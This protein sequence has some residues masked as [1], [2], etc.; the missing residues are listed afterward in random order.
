MDS[1]PSTSCSCSIYAFKFTSLWADKKNTDEFT[2]LWCDCWDI[3]SNIRA[4]W[5]TVTMSRSLDKGLQ[6]NDQYR[7]IL[8]FNSNHPMAHKINCLVT[9]FT[10]INTHCSTPNANEN[11]IFHAN[12]YITNFVRGHS[13]QTTEGHNPDL[14]ETAKNPNGGQ[15]PTPIQCKRQLQRSSPF[16]V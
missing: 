5:S 10:R 6:K 15:P 12:G 7:W 2:G 1:L 16:M 8:H 9:L 11:N 4:H 13:Q 14:R 3:S